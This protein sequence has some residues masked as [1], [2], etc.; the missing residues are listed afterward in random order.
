MA[1]RVSTTTSD[2]NAGAA[3]TAFIGIPANN[4]GEAAGDSYA[5]IEGVIGS[6]FADVLGG[7]TATT[8]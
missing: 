4:T 5:N 2:P 8:S 7:T 1:A 3:V 6:N